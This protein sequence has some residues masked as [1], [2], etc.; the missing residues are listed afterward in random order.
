MATAPPGYSDLSSTLGFLQQPNHP[1]DVWY[2]GVYSP[3]TA[4]GS[5]VLTGSQVSAAPVGV[6]GAGSSTN[7]TNQP[8]TEWNYFVFTVPSNTFGWDLRLTNVT[9]GD[10]KLYICRDQLPAFNNP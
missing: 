3:F 8:S 9:S 2:I 7:I 5:F 1:A 4:L 10:P 6:D